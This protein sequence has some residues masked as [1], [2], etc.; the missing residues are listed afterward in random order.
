MSGLT[1]PVNLSKKPA[2]KKVAGWTVAGLFLAAVAGG[3]VAF[4]MNA[5][6]SEVHGK[7]P[8]ATANPTAGIAS[9]TAKE[10]PDAVGRLGAW[11]ATINT[12]YVKFQQDLDAMSA[13]PSVGKCAVLLKDVREMQKHPIPG[14][15]AELANHWNRGLSYYELAFAECGTGDLTASGADLDKGT[16]EIG[17]A[18]TMIGQYG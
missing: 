4:L 5:P 6:H 8:A 17:K 9:P 3:T 13:T 2:R 12:D 14:D 15:N 18:T 1:A 7:A 10:T 11:F 16:A